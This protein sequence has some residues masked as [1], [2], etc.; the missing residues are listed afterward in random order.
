M[1]GARPRAAG[2]LDIATRMAN[3]STGYLRIPEFT[4]DAPARL[5]QAVASLDQ[6]RCHS[7]RLDLRGTAD[8]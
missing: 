2:S 3:A 4:K 1:S 5:T 6:E 7:L 8:R